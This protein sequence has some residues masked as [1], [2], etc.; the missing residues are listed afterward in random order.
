LDIGGILVQYKL[1]VLDLD[2][3]LLTP[4]GVVEKNACEC[5]AA[6]QDRGIHVT[7][8]TGRRTCRALPIAQS[9]QL[10]IPIVVH[11]GAVLVDPQSGQIVAKQGIPQLAANQLITE[12]CALN[13]P[14][15]LYTGENDGDNGFLL[16]QFAEHQA[17]FLT[18]IDDQVQLVERFIMGSDPI[19]IAVLAR[20][21]LLESRL[22]DWHLRYGNAMNLIVYR[23]QGYIGVDFIAKG[24]SKHEGV[25]YIL[26]KLNLSFA[27]VLAI[28]DDYNDL[29]M[30]KAAGMGVA[31]AHAPEAV[32]QAAAY[33]APANI[34]VVHVLQCFCLQKEM[35]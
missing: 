22:Q 23:S 28:G 11:N 31:M 21:S 9:L 34:G 17:E 25:N 32:K 29:G 4:Q 16:Q 14:F 18:Y 15:M 27:Q 7:L 19:K 5:I 26:N 20:E 8:A 12:L 2:G 30:I 35:E 13:L 1:V 33:I 24:C 6:V 3:T 10:T